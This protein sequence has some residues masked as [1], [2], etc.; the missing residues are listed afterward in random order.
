[1][2]DRI[3]QRQLLVLVNGALMTAVVLATTLFTKIDMPMGYLNLGDLVI[4]I[5]TCISPF[6]IAL[7][8]AGVGSAMADLLSGY[9][10]YILFTLGIKM[11]EVI[12]LHYLLKIFKEPKQMIIPFLSAGLF[13]VLLYGGADVIIMGNFNAFPGSIIGNLPQGII[14]AVLAALL[15]PQF[16]RM[17]KYLRGT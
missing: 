16:I 12:L 9:P 6:K 11:G 17:T 8:A 4:M 1:M 14:S 15:Y 5:I 3:E 7:V 13:M 10:I 2:N